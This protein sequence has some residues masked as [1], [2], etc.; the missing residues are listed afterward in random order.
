MVTFLAAIGLIAVRDWHSTDGRRLP[1]GFVRLTSEAAADTKV[2][3]ALRWSISKSGT[4]HNSTCANFKP[5]K[6][7]KSTDGTPCK[8]C[9][10]WRASRHS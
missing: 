5:K 6:L 7:C 10:G 1:G 8:H 3:N 9:R 4:R 2:P